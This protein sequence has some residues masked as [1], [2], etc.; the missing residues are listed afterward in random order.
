MTDFTKI[1]NETLTIFSPGPANKWGT[2]VFGTDNWGYNSDLDLLITKV[3]QE[4]IASADTI[5]KQPVRVL[6]MGSVT[7]TGDPDLVALQDGSGY[8]Y[9]L[10]GGVTDPDDR[11]F[12]SYTEDGATDPGWTDR[13]EES[14]DWSEA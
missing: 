4:S 3:L 1:V 12:P 8:D 13:T 9:V 2:A 14:T 10:P 11:N 5:T 6:S 7:L